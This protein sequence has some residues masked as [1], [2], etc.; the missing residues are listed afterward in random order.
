MQHHIHAAYLTITTASE[1]MAS[2]NPKKEGKPPMH[3]DQRKWEGR[4]PVLIDSADPRVSASIGGSNF[5]WL[6]VCVI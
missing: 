6:W 5:S 2:P 1:A 4:I 3:A